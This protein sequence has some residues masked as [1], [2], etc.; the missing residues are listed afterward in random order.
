MV[1]RNRSIAR[2]ASI[3][4]RSCGVET[5]SAPVGIAFW[6]SD[7]W[8]SPVPGGR[9]TIRNSA[10]P[11]SASIRRPARPS[12]SARAR[13]AH[14]RPRPIARATGNAA[15]CAATG[16]SLSSFGRR[17]GVAAEQFGLRRAVDVGVDQADFLAGAG[18]RDGEVGGQGRLA[19]AALAAGD[20]DQ[21]AARLG[22]GERDP[23]AGDAGDR[24]RGGAQVALERVAARLVEAGRV[25]DQRGDRLDQLARADAG[26]V[27]ERV[28]AAQGIMRFGHRRRHRKSA[29]ACHCFSVVTPPILGT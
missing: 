28:E 8:T 15:P 26:S 24:Q 16:I 13:R 4:D 23:G 12:P 7:S 11:Q 6:I 19:D 21:L 2:V 5:I 10:S 17:L 22:C 25:D 1:L 18:Q 9:S 3:S 14:G 27:G 29:D 20:G